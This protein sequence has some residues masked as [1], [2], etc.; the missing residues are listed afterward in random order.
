MPTVRVTL[1]ASMLTGL[2]CIMLSQTVSAQEKP[3]P[4]LE[5][6]A[7]LVGF[8]DDG[9]VNEGM[10]GG[11]GR[12]YL[13]PR[14][15]VG[16]EIVFISGDGHSHL[17]LTGNVSWDLLAPDAGRPR[18]VAPFVVAGAGLFQTRETFFADPFT[19]R[20]GAFTAGGGVKVAASD[21]FFAGVEARVGWET[22]IR[23]NGFGGLRLGPRER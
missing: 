6:S 22:H 5:V 20:E 23:I 14:V 4:E 9:I 12:V 2:F 19:S 21:R 1:F 8:A 15:S 7:G 10:I 11:A 13:S 16:P 17:V 3:R 18:A